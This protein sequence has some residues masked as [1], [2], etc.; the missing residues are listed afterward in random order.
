MAM[1]IDIHMYSARSRHD[2]GDNLGNRQLS[3]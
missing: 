2:V 3:P 1:L